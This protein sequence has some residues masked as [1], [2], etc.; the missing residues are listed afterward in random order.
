MIR[1]DYERP[2]MEI[3]DCEQECDILAGSVL[4]GQVGLK[5]YDWYDENE[6]TGV[7]NY[8]W[9]NETEE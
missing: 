2:T 7:Q 5:D 8:L 6:G 1:K 4:Q 3:V 9:N